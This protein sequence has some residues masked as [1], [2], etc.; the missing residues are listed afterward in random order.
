MAWYPPGSSGGKSV[1]FIMWKKEPVPGRDS[2]HAITVK[3][4]T[5][6]LAIHSHPSQL[7]YPVQGRPISSGLPWPPEPLLR[8]LPVVAHPLQVPHVVLVVG[9]QFPLDGSASGRNRTC[10]V[11]VSHHRPNSVTDRTSFQTA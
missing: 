2:R 4:S 11:T 6:R 3:A 10:R 7:M 1:F 8:Q 9:R 5:A